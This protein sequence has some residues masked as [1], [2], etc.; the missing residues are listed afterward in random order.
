MTYPDNS[1]PAAVCDL[2]P[3]HL[4]SRPH[5]AVLGAGAFGLALATCAQESGCKVSLFSRSIPNLDPGHPLIECPQFKL[6]EALPNPF[7]CDLFII[8]IPTQSLREVATWLKGSLSP[9]FR[10]QVVCAAKGI[11]Q[12]TL[13]LPSQILKEILG[14]DAGIATL[15]GPSFAKELTSGK[16]TAVVVAAPNKELGFKIQDILHRSHFRVYLS[17]DVIGVELGGALKNIIA[18]VAGS[19]DAL[20][21]GHNARAAVMTRGL[22]EMAQ[23]GFALGA[24]PLTFL[25]LSGLGDL[26]LTCT[27]DL[28][29][30][31]QFGM[32]L[33]QG[34]SP[35]EI[36]KLLGQ[37]VEGYHTS[38]SAFHLSQKL[39][40]DTP[41]LSTVYHVL[42]ENLPIQKAV[43]S[44]LERD[45][46]G[47][48]DWI[49]NDSK[50]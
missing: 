17:S 38:Y 45:Q 16:P 25:G 6:Y 3:V 50:K 11:E 23:M 22:Q 18:M 12:N 1:E 41:I 4:P 27:G 7:T 40:L 9:H 5:V 35:Q 34:H 28:S 44:L 37:V 47:E 42:F 14:P 2:R 33:A 20:N 39:K 30:N 26:I 21:I 15:S 36:Q 46:K 32:L 49:Q 48:F 24:S 8:A 10:P 43:F 29:R 31:R 13:L 19:V